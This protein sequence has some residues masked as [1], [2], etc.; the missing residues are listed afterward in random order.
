MRTE[1]PVLT[2]RM[3]RMK[4]CTCVEDYRANGGF[5]GF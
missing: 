2:K 1:P 4:D 3:G 5:A